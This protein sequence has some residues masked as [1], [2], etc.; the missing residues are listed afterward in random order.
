MQDAKMQDMKMQDMKLQDMKLLHILA[1]L[2]CYISDGMFNS[3]LSTL[4]TASTTSSF[5]SENLLLRIT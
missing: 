5:V 1:V 4:R 2:L 3:L